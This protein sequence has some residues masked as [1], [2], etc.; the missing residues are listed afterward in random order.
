MLRQYPRKLQPCEHH[1][2]SFTVNLKY[3]PFCKTL[4]R[5][6]PLLSVLNSFNYT[7]KSV[8]HS[9]DVILTS[10]RY[11][12]PSATNRVLKHP[13]P[14]SLNMSMSQGQVPANEFGGS[15]VVIGCNWLAPL[16]L[17]T[18]LVKPV[19]CFVF[20]NL[21]IFILDYEQAN[22]WQNRYSYK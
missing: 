19:T 1:L 8:S 6:R 5:T 14:A 9:S 7:I 20:F 11:N 2:E 13:V 22:N 21:E 3:L 4:G 17:E 12:A 15:S 18:S 16:A 10:T